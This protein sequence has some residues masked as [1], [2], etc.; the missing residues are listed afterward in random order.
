MMLQPRPAGAFGHGEELRF[1]LRCSSSP[2]FVQCNQ[3][4]CSRV[5]NVCMCSSWKETYPLNPQSPACNGAE[6]SEY[7]LDWGQVEGSMHLIY[8]GPCQS[9]EVKGLTPATTYY[10]RVQVWKALCDV[11]EWM[12]KYIQFEEKLQLEI[13]KITCC[14]LLMQWRR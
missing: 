3:R 11:T 13:N 4:W 10:C 5:M 6:I 9:Y 2:V 14:H 7:R 12:N 8:S 1:P